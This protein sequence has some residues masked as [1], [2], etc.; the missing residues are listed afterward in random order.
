MPPRLQS[1]TAPRQAALALPSIRPVQN[2]L[3][4]K[5]ER[6]QKFGAECTIGDGQRQSKSEN[7]STPHLPMEKKETLWDNFR[8]RGYS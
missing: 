6:G 8:G 5:K 2:I 4:R 7:F 3:F 1:R